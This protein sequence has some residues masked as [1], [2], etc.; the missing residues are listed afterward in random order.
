[1]SACSHCRAAAAFAYGELARGRHG[2]RRVLPTAGRRNCAVPG[3]AVLSSG[4]GSR[5]E[6]APQGSRCSPPAGNLSIED[7]P[8]AARA[9]GRCW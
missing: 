4:G 8:A 5:E 1:M 7:G 9:A 2:A 6:A 3:S